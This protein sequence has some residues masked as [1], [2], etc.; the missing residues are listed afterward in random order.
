MLIRLWYVAMQHIEPCTTYT[1][2]V[3][4][5]PLSSELGYCF[6][7]CFVYLTII[8][9]FYIYSICTAYV[10]LL[11]NMSQ[12]Q[13]IMWFVTVPRPIGFSRIIG[14][15]VVY[16]RC[17]VFLLEVLRQLILKDTSVYVLQYAA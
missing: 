3:T 17:F 10:M 15:Y 9:Y 14:R 1:H 11:R 5:S 4:V 8:L 13:L 12:K 7:K 16:K 2:N 6:G